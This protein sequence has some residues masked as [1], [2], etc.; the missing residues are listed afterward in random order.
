MVS[1]DEIWEWFC[2]LTEIEQ[3]AIAQWLIFG[4]S[5][6]VFTFEVTS[7]TL[8]DFGRVIRREVVE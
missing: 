2:S 6:L 3:L 7:D 1:K 5:D 4:N 8:K